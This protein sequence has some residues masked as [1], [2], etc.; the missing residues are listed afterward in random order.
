VPLTRRTF[1]KGTA[2]AGALT[3][4][5]PWRAFGETLQ[6]TA[7]ATSRLSRLFSGT[8]LV[9]ADMHNHT[10]LSD[11]RGDPALAFESMRTGGLDV[12][13]LTDHST[14]QY[15]SPVDPCFWG[16][17]GEESLAGINEEEWR[18]TKTIADAANR[19]GSFVAL[20]GFEWSSPAQ[21]HMNV[22]FS[23]R[24]IDPLTTG[25][26]TLGEGGGTFLC[27][28]GVPVSPEFARDYNEIVRQ[29]PTGGLTM[30]GFY[31]WLAADPS[32]PIL[33]GGRDGLASFNHPG[34]EPGRFSYFEHKPGIAS[35]VVSMEIFNRRDDYVYEGTDCGAQSPLLECLNAGWRVGLSGVTDEHGDNWGHEVGKGRTGLWVSRPSRAGVRAALG[36]RRSF[37][38]RLSGLRVDAA[39]KSRQMGQ[40]LIHSSG[41]VT[42]RLDIDRG[43]GWWGKPLSVQVL[44]PA[45]YIMPKIW[46]TE[47]VV[48]PSD[49]Q[50]VIT[51]T[52]PN[53]K[54]AD[55]NWIV[56]RIS[57]PSEEADSRADA[58]WASHGNAVAY[59]SPWFL[60][61]P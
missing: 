25:G 39:A 9:H 53:I 43:P 38:T 6:P 49:T 8:G 51:F 7:F 50:P 48:V 19:E 40:T 33:G 60:Q 16:C 2:A 1:L 17:G 36:A 55:G 37:A 18:R 29:L 22:W 32:R 31:A 5:R 52:V 24:W 10:V 44:R 28:R 42:F 12:T 15:L 57:D 58:N 45:D 21:G 30:A 13:A 4:G 23:E 41:P 56:L 27:E 47:S 3:L 26:G 46:H 14:I 34:R 11:G 20:R 54:I 59:T 35:Q 61:A